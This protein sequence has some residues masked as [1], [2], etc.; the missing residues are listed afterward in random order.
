[1]KKAVEE[2][3]QRIEEEFFPVLVTDFGCNLAV[4]FR[5][6]KMSEEDIGKIKEFM[7]SVEKSSINNILEELKGKIVLMYS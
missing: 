3:Q 7:M 1:M 6:G 2:H 4:K 5:E